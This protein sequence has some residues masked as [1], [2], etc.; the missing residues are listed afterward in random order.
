MNAKVA[1]AFGANNARIPFRKR[2]MQPD[3][4]LSI[5]AS[6]QKIA[7]S[8]LFCDKKQDLLL[9]FMKYADDTLRIVHVTNRFFSFHAFKAIL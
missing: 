3:I 2:I 8:L 5:C 1:F 6:R 4:A 9:S 7:F